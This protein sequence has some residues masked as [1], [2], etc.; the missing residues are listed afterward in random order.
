MAAR[1]GIKFTASRLNDHD[2]PAPD[3]LSQRRR[4]DLK[5]FRLQVDRQ[6]KASF[7][8]IDEAE[9]AGL[10]IKTAHPVVQVSIYDVIA[11]ENRII[12]LPPA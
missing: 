3:L 9:A 6:T 5:Q 1:T 4:P 10:V 7:D 12:T 8:S 2:E 11:G